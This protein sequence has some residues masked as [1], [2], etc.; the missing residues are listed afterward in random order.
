MSTLLQVGIVIFHIICVTSSG[1]ILLFSNNL[2]MIAIFTFL[3]GLI[4]IQTLVF[5]GCLLAKFEKGIPYV[6]KLTNILKHFTCTDIQTNNLEK[7]L[8]G[9]TLIGYLSKLLVLSF[10]HFYKHQ[11]WLEF[12]M[13]NK[14]N[15]LIKMIPMF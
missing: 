11:S 3:V 2:T 4:F 13:S 1:F 9:I 10:L 6:D 5:D 14:S 8:V 12:I 15:I 7:I